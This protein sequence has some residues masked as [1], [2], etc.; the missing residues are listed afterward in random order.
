[1]TSEFTFEYK[2]APYNADNDKG[3]DNLQ[4]N[5]LLIRKLQ[6]K[7]QKTLFGTFTI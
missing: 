3:I 7:I 6:F 5:W 1:M 2:F 4:H